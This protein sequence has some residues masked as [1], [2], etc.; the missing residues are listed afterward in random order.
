M[1][2]TVGTQILASVVNAEHRNG[3]PGATQAEESP[4]SCADLQF[5]A[6]GKA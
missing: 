6:P 4:S 5:E 3:A 2:H 1:S